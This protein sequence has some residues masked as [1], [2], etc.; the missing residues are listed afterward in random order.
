VP[1]FRRFD[2]FTI[3]PILLVSTLMTAGCGISASTGTGGNGG[4]A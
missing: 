1:Q 2:F 4:S 3:V